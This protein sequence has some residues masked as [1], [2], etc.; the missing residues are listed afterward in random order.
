MKKVI[1]INLGGLPYIIDE[2]AYEYLNYYFDS[3]RRHF[4]A[5][6]GCD[7]I[8]YDIELRMS[9]LFQEQLKSKQI[10]TMH[11]LTGVIEIMGKPEDFGAEAVDDASFQQ[12]AASSSTSGHRIHRTGKRLYR[13]EENKMLGGVVSGLTAYLGIDDPLWLRIL[14]AISITFG[15]GIVP[16]IILWAI[17][18]AAKT[19]A[20]KLAM[21]GEPINIDNIAKTIE[22]EIN[23]LS[24]RINKYSDKYSKKYK[25]KNYKYDYRYQ[26]DDGEAEQSSEYNYEKKKVGGNHIS[27]GINVL[28]STVGTTLLSIFKIITQIAKPII[29]VIVGFAMLFLTILTVGWLASG[30]MGHSI[31]DFFIPKSNGF[32]ILAPLAIIFLVLIPLVSFILY[33]SKWYYPHNSKKYGMWMGAAWTA[34]VIILFGSAMFTIKEYNSAYK[35]ENAYDLSFI[36]NKK[37]DINFEGARYD[38]LISLGDHMNFDGDK[39]QMETRNIRLLNAE[40]DK[41]KLVEFV[42]SRGKNQTEAKT[43]AT[44]LIHDFKFENGVLTFPLYKNFDKSTGYRGEDVHYTLYVPKDVK[45]ALPDENSWKVWYDDDMADKVLTAE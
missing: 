1:N 12:D 40:D 32:T 19:S 30:I 24:E 8:I 17:V 43:K 9:E 11:E 39:M 27:A 36:K 23:D 7:E 41:L 2:D 16:Y 5:S 10:I 33:L 38:G 45:V 20:D 44:K 18:P 4:S 28:F 31:L 34:C 13:D 37:I 35:E 14:F 21:R 29:S 6:E 25:N 26:Y 3:L 22:T 15:V 42:S